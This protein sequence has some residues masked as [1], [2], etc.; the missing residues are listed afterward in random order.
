MSIINKRLGALSFPIGDSSAAIQLFPAGVFDA[1]RGALKGSGPWRLDAESAQRLISSVA[2]RIND[3]LVDYEHQSVLSS[4]NG[5]PAPAAGW[6][7]PDSLVFDGEKGLLATAVV[8]TGAAKDYIANDQYRYIS[9]VF[10]YDGNTGTVLDLLSVALT[11]TP[12][13]DGMDAVTLAAA[14]ALLI[15]S[16]QEDSPMDELL[17]RLRY[18]LNLPLTSTATDIMAELDKLKA[19]IGGGDDAVAATGLVAYLSAK[20]NHIAALA[21]AQAEPD[22]TQYAPIAALT[23]VQEE[24]AALKAEKAERDIES[25]IGP[26]LGDGRLL[27]AQEQWARDLGKSNI[28]ALSQFLATA[29]PIAA[30]SGMQTGGKAPAADQGVASLT[31]EE[32]AVCKA[33]G[34]D[35]EQFLKSK[36]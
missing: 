36:G 32:L 25:L 30:L 14:S 8:W 11:N 6:I 20:D 29:A 16:T 21:L 33:T 27:P 26:A 9:P 4:Q 19:M 12:A 7:K 23:A 17:E 31:T 18:L 10:I 28:A 22:P 34:I 2:A 5:K 13:I 15:S 35:P 3:V 24:V 1:P